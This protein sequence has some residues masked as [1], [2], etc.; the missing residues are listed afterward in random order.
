MGFMFLMGIIFSGLKGCEL[1]ILEFYL[2]IF[3]EEFLDL[4][5]FLL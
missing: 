3:I 4:I 2:E 1:K 5:E